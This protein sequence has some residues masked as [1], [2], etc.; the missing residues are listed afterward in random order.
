MPY[1]LS[2]YRAFIAIFVLD[3]CGH[4][5]AYVPRVEAAITRLQQEGRSIELLQANQP[6]KKAA[7]LVGV[8]NLTTGDRSVQELADRFDV[9]ATPTTVVLP[10]GIG[11]FKVDSSLSNSQIAFLLDDTLR[12]VGA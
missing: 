2:Q 7:V 8:Y 11:A 9:Q 4:C 10:Q 6:P 5:E 3:G 1:D 12:G